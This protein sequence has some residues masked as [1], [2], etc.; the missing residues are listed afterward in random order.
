MAKGMTIGVAAREA[1]VGVE[2]IRF[3]QRRGLIGAPD[4]PFGG[5][6]HYTSEIVKRIRFIKRAQSLGF[7]LDEIVTLLRLDSARACAETR[8][9]ARGKLRVIERKLA[10]LEQMRE[11]LATLVA[12]CDP[13][14]PGSDCPIIRRLAQDEF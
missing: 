7:S 8:D 13:G 10:D 1:G 2:T 14:Q 9:L 3:Y 11:A 5:Y 12:Q 6:R 4:K